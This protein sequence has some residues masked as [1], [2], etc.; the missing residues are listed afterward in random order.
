MSKVLR[1]R[2]LW[3]G[4]GL[5]AAIVALLVTVEPVRLTVHS[6]LNVLREQSIEADTS[7]EV[8]SVVP[9][10]GDA[11]TLHPDTFIITEI[12]SPASMAIGVAELL[13]PLSFEPLMLDAPPGFTPATEYTL[14]HGGSWRVDI[15]FEKLQSF[16]AGAEV[17]IPL[18]ESLRTRAATIRG[19]EILVTRWASAAPAGDPLIL[20]QFAAPNITAPPEVDLELIC[21]ELVRETLPPVLARRIDI[22]EIALYRDVLGLEPLDD[23]AES[24]WLQLPGGQSLLF[25]RA[26]GSYAA[27]VGPL[28]R[29]ALMRLAGFESG[30]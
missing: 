28:D 8:P 23:G 10:P 6:V 15:D 24:Q 25:W 11:G 13:P 30:A 9:T 29:D 27:L 21:R 18:P 2:G 3:V 4:L 12:E 22:T 5:T 19:P 20:V 26:D 14:Q 17:R 1:F 16:L 7:R